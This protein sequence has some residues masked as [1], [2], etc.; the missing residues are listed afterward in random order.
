M[1]TRKNIYLTIGIILIVLNLLVDITDF[2]HIKLQ[3]QN[4]KSGFGY[5]IGSQFLLIIGLILVRMAYK[6]KLR[7]ERTQLQDMINKIGSE[8]QPRTLSIF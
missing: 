6:L 4:D 8:W 2:T 5:V 7:I 1:K 3:V